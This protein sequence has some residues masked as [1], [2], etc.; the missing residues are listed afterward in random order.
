MK[1]MVFNVAA[2]SGGAATILD[3]YYQRFIDDS[4]TEYVLVLSKA[5]Y[6]ST[7]NVTVLNFPWVKK[8]RFHR[9]F[10]DYFFAPRLVKKYQA[11]K[12][13]SLQNIIVPM[14]KIYQTIYLHNALVFSD[15]R[16][17]FFQDQNIWINQ[18][19]IGR[20]I[21][22]SVKKADK[23]IVQ[24]EW[25]KKAVLNKCSVESEKI[26]VE[27][28]CINKNE[29]LVP[30]AIDFEV[31]TF[32]YPASSAIFKNHEIIIEAAKVLKSK[33]LNFQIFFTLDVSIDP[34]AKKIFQTIKKNNLPI[35]FLGSIS[36]AEVY[37]YYKKSILL[38][39]SIIETVG[40]PLLEASIVGSRMI[41][42]DLPYSREILNG[43]EDV[44]YFN[45]DDVE[46]IV[47]LMEEYLK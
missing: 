16:Y 8:S 1:L 36:R 11:D 32:F 38:F 31:T 19:I 22:K 44:G 35:I 7:S 4:K 23:V 33:N 3:M 14:K 45:F 15:K 29:V 41:V 34:R 28:P 40:L 13:M 5:Q 26:E 21:I 42:A 30:D 24:T 47:I 46:K 9:L 2:E 20:K 10:F 27:L 12:I 37:G 17:S 39:P 6:K 25:M 43:Y 18:N